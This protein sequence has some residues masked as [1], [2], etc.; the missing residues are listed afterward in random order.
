MQKK[1]MKRK[2]ALLESEKTR[3]NRMNRKRMKSDGGDDEQD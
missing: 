1:T 3:M 2:P